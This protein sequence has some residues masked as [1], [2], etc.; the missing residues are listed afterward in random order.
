MYIMNSRNVIIGSAVIIVGLLI[1][2]WAVSWI[3]GNFKTN[4]L[5]TTE[6]VSLVASVDTE[7]VTR[8]TTSGEIVGDEDYRSIRISVSRNKRTLE[9]MSG[10]NNVVTDAKSY[11]NNQAAFESFLLA[12]ELEGFTNSRKGATDDERG[13]CPTGT[14]TVYEALGNTDIQQRLW[15]A[16]CTKKSQTFAGD[17]SGIQSLFKAQIPDYSELTKSVKL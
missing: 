14:R 16:T 5:A 2:V 15:S 7:L 11:K 6:N 9:I 13:Y 10:Y 3:S 1:V 4:E 8:I 12:I 17:S